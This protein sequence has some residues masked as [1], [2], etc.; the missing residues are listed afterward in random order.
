[1]SQKLSAIGALLEESDAYP[2]P[3]GTVGFGMNR[4]RLIEVLQ[5]CTPLLSSIS[6][7]PHHVGDGDMT[8]FAI[9]VYVSFARSELEIAA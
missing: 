9:T 4:D 8:S 2:T 6:A 1:M 7:V 3:E 5:E